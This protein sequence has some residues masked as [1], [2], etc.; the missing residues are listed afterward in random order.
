MANYKVNQEDYSIDHMIG[1][2]AFEPQRLSQSY[3]QF[4]LSD[5]VDIYGNSLSA[6]TS[7]N[8]GS[9]NPTTLLR[10]ALTSHG[11][12]NQSSELISIRKGNEVIKFA[13]GVNFDDIDIAVTDWIG[14]DMENLISAWDALRY[15]P[16][17]GK[18]NPQSKYKKTGHIVQYSPD[19]EIV[20]SWVLKGAWIDSVKYGDYDRSAASGTREISFVLHVDKAY[21]EYRGKAAI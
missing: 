14:A 12:P 11:M 3:I 9:Y 15:N 16:V 6:L 18:V 8:L 2:R 19:G 20:R 5:L 21:P 13:G 17:T 4:D 7:T 1:D 10:L